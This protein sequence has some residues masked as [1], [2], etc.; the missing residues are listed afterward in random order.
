M[1]LKN[2]KTG[3]IEEFE[4]M[5]RVFKFIGNQNT[6]SS[7]AEFI[8]EW[9][10]Y[11]EPKEHYW[12]IDEDGVLVCR[13]VGDFTNE[14]MCK[15]IGNYFETREE[16]EKAVERLRAWKRLKD[17]GFKFDGYHI[18]AGEIHF[19]MAIQREAMDEFIKDMGIC[20]GGEE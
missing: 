10:D 8:D 16:A 17:K 9:E 5:T 13:T 3:E 19:N 11:E 2:K 6:Y 14:G 20:F 12:V 18:P 4:D 7:L 1:K 15:Q